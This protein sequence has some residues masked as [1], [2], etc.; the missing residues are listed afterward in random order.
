M[1]KTK[2]VS[3]LEKTKI[4][5]AEYKKA[6]ATIRAAWQERGEVISGIKSLLSGSPKSDFYHNREE[7]GVSGIIPAIRHLYEI[8]ASLELSNAASHDTK[9]NLIEIIRWHI[10]PN[11]AVKNR[12]EGCYPE[13]PIGKDHTHPSR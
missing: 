10:N 2:K 1:T 7:I 8:I 4:E 12:Q 6:E 11:T 3:E 13:C 9:I 5:L